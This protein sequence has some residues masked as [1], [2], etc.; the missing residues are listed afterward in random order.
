MKVADTSWL[1]ALV[2]EADLHHPEARAQAAA[3]AALAVPAEAWSE[4]VT[5]LWWRRSVRGDPQP[6]QT[7]L[8]VARAVL[9]TPSI[10]VGHGC[11]AKDV[12][13]VMKNHPALSYPDA[14]G[15]AAARSRGCPL[16]TFDAAQAAA[17]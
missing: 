14:A 9:A 5:L 4:F 16:L 6:R 15:I 2:D 11:A 12:L 3:E 8:R 1:Y 7:A 17:L 13:D 10:A